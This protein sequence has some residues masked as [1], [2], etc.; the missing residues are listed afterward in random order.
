MD[1]ATGN[2][3]RVF[4]YVGRTYLKSECRKFERQQIRVGMVSVSFG[5]G[6]DGEPDEFVRP[7]ELSANGRRKVAGGLVAAEAGN[8]HRLACGSTCEDDEA[9][10]IHVGGELLDVVVPDGAIGNPEAIFDVEVVVAFPLFVQPL[11]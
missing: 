8:V 2:D 1:A 3:S 9:D 7:V 11:V 10:A 4:S 5:H 6:A